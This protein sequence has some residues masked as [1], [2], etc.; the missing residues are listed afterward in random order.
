MR[1]ISYLRVSTDD[2]GKSGLGLEAQRVMVAPYS[3][4]AEYV[5]VVSGKADDR[6][7]LVLALAHAKRMKATLVIAKLDRLGRRVAFIANL[8]ESGV[9]FVCAD[10]PNAQAFELHI[11]AALAEKEA[12]MISDRTKA[13]LAACKA[14]GVALGGA[15]EGASHVGLASG[16]AARQATAQA[17]AASVAPTVRALQARGLSLRAMASELN[18]MGITTKRGNDWSAKT[19]QDLIATL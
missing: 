10:M 15:R 19:M 9:P 6:A 2:Q 17:F 11:Y 1:Y 16:L 13:A 8:M 12:R 14:R 18:V 7:Q 4:V 5:E 3:P